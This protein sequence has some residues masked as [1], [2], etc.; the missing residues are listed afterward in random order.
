MPT[1][2]GW[3]VAVVGVAIAA[4]GRLFGSGTL[5]QLG[6]GFIILVVAAVV[7]VRISRHELDIE[8]T[9]SPRRVYPD[10][11]VTVT[12]SLTNRGR[13]S[14][15]LL[16]LEDHLPPGLFG[17]A[18]FAV[19]GIEPQ[20][21]RQ[22]SI[23]VTPGRRGRYVLGPLQ[24]SM[25]DPFG[26][27]RLRQTDPGRSTLLVHPRAE[28]LVAPKDPGEHRT[29]TASASRHPTGARGEDFYTLRE[30]VD[31]DDL[32]KIHWPSTAKQNRYMIRQEETPW[33]TRATIMLDDFAGAHGGSG[34]SSS[35]ERCVD[36]AASLVD[37]YQRVGFGYRLVAAIEPGVPPGRGSE[38]K[39]RC[40]DFLAL[41]SLSDAPGG[42]PLLVRLAELDT[43]SAAEASLLVVTGTLTPEV[44]AA[45]V[46][47]GR[48]HRQ[49]TVIS[50]P[51]HRFGSET[52]KSRWEGESRVVEA[53]R[54]LGRAGV[55][56]MVLGPDESLSAAWSSLWQ[57]KGEGRDRPWAPRPELV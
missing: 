46:N 45:V 5:E 51:A 13:G 47:C 43:Q 49:T 52:T 1:L 16:L 24:I 29:I 7:V 31:G 26:L 21:A 22:S 15:P 30:Y 8:R 6:Y 48:R 39:D 27:A 17:R 14:A 3:I 25:V 33:H 23:S 4:L 54:L 18:R 41:I 56:C 44:S 19:H 37:L 50:F 9:V 57:T 40:L 34:Q 42:N 38:H 20:G 12:I 55:R 2:R 35:F 32:R 28:R 11:T 10:E 36:T 53:T